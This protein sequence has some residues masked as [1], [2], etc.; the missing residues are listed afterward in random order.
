MMGKVL[1]IVYPLFLYYAVVLVTMTVAQWFV[2]AG[3]EQ[4]VICQLAASVTA[5][6]CMLPFYR[7]DQDPLAQIFDIIQSHNHA[8]IHLRGFIA[9]I[10]QADY[11][12]F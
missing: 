4:Y 2:G 6:P 12:H 9:C 8:V 1:K 10:P 5:I 7:Q 3:D 11:P